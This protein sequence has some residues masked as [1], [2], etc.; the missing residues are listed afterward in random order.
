MSWARRS[1]T[2]RGQKHWSAA[3]DTPLAKPLAK[4][5]WEQL[6]ARRF[7]RDVSILL[8]SVQFQPIF[9]RLFLEEIHGHGQGES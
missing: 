8:F 1:A 4:I 7:Q 2:L 5:G 9:I 6:A 3:A